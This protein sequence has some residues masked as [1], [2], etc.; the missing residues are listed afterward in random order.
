M[1]PSRR[2]EPVWPALLLVVVSASCA[3]RA[4][5][6]CSQ[7]SYLDAVAAYDDEL[8]IE[9]GSQRLEAKRLAARK[10]AIEAKLVE[11]ERLRR[12]PRLE[13]AILVLHEAL[14][15]ETR[16]HMALP[17]ELANEQNLLI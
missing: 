15:W 4:D 16:W 13:N 2:C 10:S 7:G 8:A 14:S 11:A 9:P 6:L 1:S 5:M 12:F 17:A 3:S